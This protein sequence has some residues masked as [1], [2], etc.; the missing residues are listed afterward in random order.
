MNSRKTGRIR[1]WATVL[2]VIGVLAAGIGVGVWYKLFRVEPQPFDSIE[3]RFKYGS[4]GTEEAEGIPYWIWLVL[5]RVFSD[6]L[7]G[8]GGYASLGLV[9]EEGQEVPV[10]F[11]KKTIGFPRLGI[12]CSLCHSGTY[13]TDP[14][15]APHVVPG[16]PATRL[17]LLGYQRFLIACAS[18]ER[19]TADKILT[20]IDYDVKLSAVDRA[21]YRYVLI[22]QTKK[23][24]RQAKE[25]FAWTDVRPDWGRGRIDPFNPV[26]FHQL[27]MDPTGDKSIG[28]SDMEPLWAMASRTNLPLHWDGL[29]DSLI[30]VVLTGA[31][32]DG[33]TPKSLPV[34]E[35]KELEGW[36]KTLQSPKY[37]FPIDWELALNKG[38]PLFEEHCASCHGEGGKRFGTVIPW[39]EVKTDRHRLD[40]W[41]QANESKAAQI[42]NQKYSQYPW[43]FT[44]FKKSGGYV[45]VP[46]TGLWLRAPYLHNG[47][48]PTLEDMLEPQAKRP[49]V[50]YRGFDVYDR[51]RTG[52][53]HR[54]EEI[55]KQD[56][57]LLQST[58]PNELLKKIYFRYD[59]AVDGNSNG[60][61][62]GQAYGTELT[63]DDKKALVEYL[64]T[65]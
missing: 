28:N 33:A 21:L 14:R 19:F 50:F 46:M 36:L 23:S 55:L 48:I 40:M 4:I 26:K 34:Q 52:F 49:K 47:S 57:L 5:P 32:G 22:P 63:G 1:V 38:K 42:Y 16:A 41:T 25:R 31:I 10:G 15:Q 39:D 58:E 37:P 56:P 18:D 2:I 62:D 30:E 61:H 17:D 27:G 60:G 65:L 12:N 29:N 59:I 64:K 3:A 43:G 35:L 54:E 45:A 24:L 53:V 20:E 51:A 8:P 6:L 11:S 9:W 44:H 13:R 7:P